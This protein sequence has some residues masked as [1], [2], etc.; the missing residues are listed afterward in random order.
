MNRSRYEEL[1]ILAQKGEVPKLN[2]HS[3]FLQKE[4]AMKCPK[5]NARIEL[6][7]EILE[8]SSTVFLTEKNLSACNE[9][10]GVW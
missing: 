7:L 6:R 10:R 8:R 2:V 5:C 1:K 9:K 4:I 3:K